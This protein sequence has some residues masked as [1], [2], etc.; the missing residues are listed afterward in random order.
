MSETPKGRVEEIRAKAKAFHLQRIGASILT[1]R[2]WS[3]LLMDGTHFIDF[4]IAF[5][6]EFN[7]DLLEIN[8]DLLAALERISDGD[9]KCECDHSTEDC[10]NKVDEYCPKCISDAAIARAKG[11][12]Q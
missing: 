8:A 12:S 9:E 4:A 6:E 7:K 3:G 2:E 1:P 10:C 5:A 11:Q